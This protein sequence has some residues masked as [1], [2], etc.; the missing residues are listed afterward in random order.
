V[1]RENCTRFSG[2][3]EKVDA[4]RFTH[5]F[6]KVHPFRGC[7]RDRPIGRYSFVEKT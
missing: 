4:G 1:I 2:Y 6:Y 7:R 3:L 5:V